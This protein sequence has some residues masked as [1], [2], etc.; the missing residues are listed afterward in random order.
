MTVDDF[1]LLHA[2]FS[3]SFIDEQISSNLRMANLLID[4]VGSF[5]DLREDAIG[6]LT[7]HLLSLDKQA[8]KGG[9]AMQ[10]KTSKKVGD[11]Q[12][13]YA[14]QTND[15]EWYNLSSFGQKLL[16]LLDM[17]PRGIGAFVV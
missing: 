1:K 4:N 10:Q 14:A 7:A 9:A 3:Q 13:T 5:G 16:W 6:L 11:V 15:R 17:Q 12:Y 2:D 8:G